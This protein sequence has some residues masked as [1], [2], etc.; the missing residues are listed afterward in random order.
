M[1]KMKKFFLYTV[2]AFVQLRAMDNDE[3]P[4]QVNYACTI[5][6]TYATSNAAS[7]VRFELSKAL[8][9]G[10]KSMPIGLFSPDLAKKIRAL[11]EK[12]AAKVALLKDIAD[13]NESTAGGDKK[14]NEGTFAQQC[15][16]KVN[17]YGQERAM[18]LAQALRLLADQV[19]AECERRKRSNPT[20]PTGY[21]GG[22]LF[23][24]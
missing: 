4:Q 18:R 11:S 2:L 15:V 14:S 17:E 3:L 16:E 8:F 7:Q 20:S 19:M 6:Q 12:R 24:K 22:F 13:L 9:V 10:V 23:D 21:S 5:L 1:K